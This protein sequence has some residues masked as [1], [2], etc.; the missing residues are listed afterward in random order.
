MIG[1]S[2]SWIWLS[3]LPARDRWHVPHFE[4][5]GDV[6]VWQGVSGGAVFSADTGP[7]LQGP[8]HLLVIHQST[9]ASNLITGIQK[10][11]TTDSY[12]S[13]VLQLVIDSDDNLFPDFFLD[14][15][16][17]L[18]YQLVVDARPR[19]YVPVVCQEAVLRA[20]HGDSTLAGHLGIDKIT[21]S[22]SHAFYWPGLHADVAHFM[23]T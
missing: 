7:I 9:G 10:S 12:L 8:H 5:F 18:C 11:V 22:V 3:L 20:A 13:G 19:A 21:A 4:S 17:T 23:R 15:R 2:Y 6:G 14:V 1:L 16:E